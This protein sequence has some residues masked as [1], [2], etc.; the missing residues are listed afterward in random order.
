MAPRDVYSVDE[1]GLFYYAQPNNTKRLKDQTRRDIS[2][3]RKEKF[4]GA[5][6]ERSHTLALVVNMQAVRR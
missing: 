5:K 2:T 3:K 1:T 4:V 6:L